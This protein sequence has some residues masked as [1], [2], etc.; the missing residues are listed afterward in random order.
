MLKF[1]VKR[2]F[3]PAAPHASNEALC[4]RNIGNKTNVCRYHPTSI[5]KRGS[6]YYMWINSRN[7]VDVEPELVCKTCR[8][9]A[10][11]E[12]FI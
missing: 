7:M 12:V 8:R 10:E 6:D 3:R 9:I 4:G 5:E 2:E 1:H 11:S